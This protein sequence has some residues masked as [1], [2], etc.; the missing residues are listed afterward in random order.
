MTLSMIVHLNLIPYNSV[1]GKAI[2]AYGDDNATDGVDDV[3]WMGMIHRDDAVCSS[4]TL[5]FASNEQTL[6][7]CMRNIGGSPLLVHHRSWLR[8]V[9]RSV[10]PA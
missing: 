10:D 5:L 2:S 8:N 7:Q 3:V 4:S 9:C 6:M 1:I